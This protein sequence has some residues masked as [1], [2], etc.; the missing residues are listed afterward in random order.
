M[1]NPPSEHEHHNESQGTS[2]PFLY[3][4]DASL[5]SI[6]PSITEASV[7]GRRHLSSVLLP[8]KQDPKLSMINYVKNAFHWVGVGYHEP[9]PTPYFC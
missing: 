1:E 3:T 6:P 8:G 5:S 4:K 7:D 9:K 2:R